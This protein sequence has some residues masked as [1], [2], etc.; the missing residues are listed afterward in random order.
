MAGASEHHRAM[1]AI[2]D[3]MVRLADLDDG[4]VRRIR[5]TAEDPP[6]VSVFDVLG[7]I[8]CYAPDNSHNQLERLM[9]AH[10]EIRTLITVFKFP[11]RGQRDT[12]VCSEKDLQNILARLPG[13]AAADYRATGMLSKR[14]KRALERDD[15]YV[16]KYSND[17]TVVK[18]GRSHDVNKRRKHLEAGQNFHVE[19]I[20]TFPGSGR[21]E[22]HV[23]ALLSQKRSTAGAGCEWFNVNAAEAVRVISETIAA[24]NGVTS[25]FL[26]EASERHQ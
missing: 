5:K 18:I 21:L 11:G 13:R 23:H 6:R 9:S 26:E 16:M 24:E 10:P 14:P 17:S 4:T 2:P 7:A 3:L 1:N 20:A 25:N 8:T 22:D 19:V 12:P 15:L